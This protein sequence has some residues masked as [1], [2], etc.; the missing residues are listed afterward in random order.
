MLY[1]EVP[2]AKAA[3]AQQDCRSHAAFCYKR[4]RWG[5]L[6]F[7]TL[8]AAAASKRESLHIPRQHLQRCRQ[9]LGPSASESEQHYLSAWRLALHNSGCSIEAAD[10]SDYR[11]TFFSLDGHRYPAISMQLAN[12]SRR[13]SLGDNLLDRCSCRLCSS[14][15]VGLAQQS[16]DSGVLAKF[17]QHLLLVNKFPAN[18]G[19]SLLLPIRHDDC[20][21]RC[22]P[23]RNERGSIYIPPLS[24]R[25]REA[26]LTEEFLLT[27][28]AVCDRFSLTA[29]RNHLLDGKSEPHDHFKLAPTSCPQDCLL[30]LVTQV[31]RELANLGPTHQVHYLLPE[32]TPF[33]TLAICGGDS[34]Q[35]CKVVKDL[36]EKLELD[37][38]VYTLLYA[39]G[40]WLITPRSRTALADYCEFPAFGASLGAHGLP[41]PE[42]SPQR[43]ARIP[44]LVLHK[45]SGFWQSRL[46]RNQWPQRVLA[47]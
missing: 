24:G 39:R 34:R 6:D 28:M 13:R 4:A 26:L 27:V 47:A 23:Q 33:E 22:T 15:Q 5:R 7:G 16:A 8:S 38:E 3:L 18:I 36:T 9:I 41:D 30:D 17:D 29:R 32:S 19:D 31:E 14:I 1:S 37:D 20:S 21:R 42:H 40:C 45:G 43:Y 10:K 44:E 35:L 25:T 46:G 11:R 12:G 2:S